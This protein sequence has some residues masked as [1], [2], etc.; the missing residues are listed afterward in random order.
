MNTKRVQ[1]KTELISNR[2]RD[3][4]IAGSFASGQLPSKLDLASHF[5]VSHRTMEMVLKRLRE[6]GLIR[7]VRGTGIFVNTDVSEVTNITPRLAVM[8][9]PQISVFEDEPYNTLRVESFSRGLVPVNLPMPDR[10]IKLSLQEKTLLTQ[11][12]K[13][14]IRGVLYNG[15]GYRAEPF[16]DSWRNLRSVGL[17][18]FDSENDPPGSTVLTD[19]EAGAEK[20]A[21]H[22]VEQGCKKI[23]VLAG[24]LPPDVP[25]SKK[26]WEKHV[27]TQFV[28]GVSRVAADAGIAEPDLHFI[29]N[30]PGTVDMF[31]PGLSEEMAYLLKKYDAVICTVDLLAYTVVVHARKLGIPIPE[32]LLVSAERDTAWCSRFGVDLTSLSLCYGKLSKKAFD[33][34]ECGGIHHEKVIPELIIRETSSRK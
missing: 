1:T 18:K 14:P 22:F 31:T 15:R 34:L 27:S 7:G 16:L 29:K 20:I 8:F 13:A 2:L 3:E 30:P 21:R 11:V 10:Y 28:N 33:I 24:Y 6:E 19:Y 9:L 26:Y 12:L 5:N 32:K 25:K 4:I 17:I 23:L